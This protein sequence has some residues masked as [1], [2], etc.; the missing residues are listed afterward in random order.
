MLEEENFVRLDIRKKFLEMNYNWDGIR[1]ESTWSLSGSEEK[2][3][4]LTECK[5]SAPRL[6]DKM[7]TWMMGGTNLAWSARNLVCSTAV[8]LSSP[9]SSA[10][11]WRSA[12]WCVRGVRF[13]FFKV[14]MDN[15]PILF[16]CISV[17][18][19]YIGSILSVLKT[20]PSPVGCIILKGNCRFI[21]F[22]DCQLLLS[23]SLSFSSSSSSSSSLFSCSAVCVFLFL[24]SLKYI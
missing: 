5:I 1:L 2:P 18:Y 22:P 13:F 21:Y 24:D 6:I 10:A 7:I 20:L 11:V 9:R 17:L 14:H 4:A 8:W 12:L 23:L 3:A 15:D 19:I 16:A